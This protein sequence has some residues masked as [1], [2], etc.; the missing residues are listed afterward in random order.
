MQPA[1]GATVTASGNGLSTN[2]IFA[3]TSD[4]QTAAGAQNNQLVTPKTNI[5]LVVMLI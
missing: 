3:I 4:N 1:Y 2:R 5:K